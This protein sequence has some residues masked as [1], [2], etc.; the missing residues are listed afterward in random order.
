MIEPDKRKAIVALHESGMSLKELSRRLKLSRNT[1]RRIIKQAGAVVRSPRKDRI[2]PDAELLGKLHVDCKGRVQRIHEKLTEQEGVVLGYS[3]LARKLRQLGLGS[4]RKRCGRVADVAGAEMQHDTSRYRLCVGGSLRWFA[5]SLLYFRFS[6]IRYLKFY[7]SFTRFVM[8]CFFHEALTF[9]GYSAPVCI[10]DNTNLA[11][12]RGLGKDAVMI[13][14]MER[15]AADYGFRFLCHERGHANRKAGEERGFFTVETNFFPGRSFES[16][17]DLNRQALEWATVRMAKRPVGK[18]KL[19][20]VEA[21]EQEKPHLIA[22]SPYI[23]PPYRIHKRGVDQ[24]GYA[25]FDANYYWVPGDSREEVRVLEYADRLKISRHRVDLAEYTKP[26]DGVKNQLFS[27][28]GMPPPRFQPKHRKHPTAQ[29]EKALRA[30]S[31][32]VAAYLDFALEPKGIPRHH[33]IRDLAR[34]QRRLAPAL[35][36]QTV[37]RALKYRI[38]DIKIVERI[39]LLYLGAGP[40][41][42]LCAEVDEEFQSRPSYLEGR[43]GDE[44]DLSVY[45]KLLEDDNE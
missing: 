41:E 35:F 17:E 3:T 4:A 19:I 34:L 36:L 24:Y 14:E 9:F 32:G 37:A 39:A 25:A 42:T 21:F 30:L 31:P 6:K 10:I 23:E 29:E 40:L 11:R 44:V 7:R 45:G 38:R 15:F 5:A 8:K 27:P 22:L 13:P 12:L 18:A 33:F 26:S 28:E 43:L 2:E 1:V 16:L 20:P